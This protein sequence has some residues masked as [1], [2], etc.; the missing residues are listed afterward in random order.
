MGITFNQEFLW[1]FFPFFVSNESIDLSVVSAVNDKVLKQQ[2]IQIKGLYS[3]SC[4]DHQSL[5]CCW[6][7]PAGVLEPGIG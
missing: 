5:S 7:A 4:D 2:T 6:I 1:R 3:L